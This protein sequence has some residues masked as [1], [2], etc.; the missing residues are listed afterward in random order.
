MIAL[1]PGPSVVPEKAGHVGLPAS[2]A[3]LVRQALP[4]LT[5]DVAIADWED[6]L[7]AVK[8]RL[9]LTVGKWLVSTPEPLV[10]AKAGW[11]Q[12]SVLE[13]VVALDQLQNTLTN[14]LIRLRL[15]KLELDAAN[16]AL[17]QARAELVAIRE[18]RLNPDRANGR[19]G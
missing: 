5:S 14:E 17:A 3:P 11:I 10:H 4:K 8:D 9:R 19:A 15:L 12:A 2:A 6:L 18:P 16:L 1:V 7:N 13:C